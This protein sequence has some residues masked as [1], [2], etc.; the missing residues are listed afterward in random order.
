MISMT[1]G[2]E[3]HHFPSLYLGLVPRGLWRPPPSL[4]RLDVTTRVTLM[5]Q[6]FHFVKV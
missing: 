6:F 3:I 4:G 5:M 1:L 2:E